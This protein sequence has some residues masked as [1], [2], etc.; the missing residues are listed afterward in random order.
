MVVVSGGGEGV[1]ES[2]GVEVMESAGSAC[3]ERWGWV[4][5]L[6]GGWA[7]VPRMCRQRNRGSSAVKS[8]KIN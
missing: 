1:W 2:V 7:A 4:Q 3:G 8:P 5:C 6:R